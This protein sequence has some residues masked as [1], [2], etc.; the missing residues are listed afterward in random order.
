MMPSFHVMQVALRWIY[1]QGASFIMR[2]FKKERMFENVQIFDGELS[3]EELDKIQQIHQRRGTLGEDF[4]HPE[5]PIKSVEELW[6]G[7]L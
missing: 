4:I 5:G 7:D 6:D 2:T 3:Q 1:E